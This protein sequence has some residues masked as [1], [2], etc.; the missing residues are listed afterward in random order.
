MARLA[1]RVFY[2]AEPVGSLEDFAGLRT[3]GSADQSV[4]FHQIDQVKGK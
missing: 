1:H 2:F 4:A 3:V